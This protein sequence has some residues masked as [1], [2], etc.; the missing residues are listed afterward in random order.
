MHQHT[1][2][3]LGEVAANINS[4]SDT[5]LVIHTDISST[6][7]LLSPPGA[8]RNEFLSS[9]TLTTRGEGHLDQTTAQSPLV[10]QSSSSSMKSCKSDTPATSPV[11]Q[12]KEFEASGHSAAVSDSPATT[13]IWQLPTKEQL[14]ATIL[15][16]IATTLS[17]GAIA[18]MKNPTAANTKVETSFRRQQKKELAAAIAS[19]RRAA[20]FDVLNEEGEDNKSNWE[21][22]RVGLNRLRDL[23]SENEIA[24]L[25]LANVINECISDSTRRP[26]STAEASSTGPALDLLAEFTCRLFEDDGVNKE[27][28]ERP[29]PTLSPASTATSEREELDTC[30]AVP[31]YPSMPGFAYGWEPLTWTVPIWN[32]LQGAMADIIAELLTLEHDVDVITRAEAAA[33]DKASK[34]KT[35]SPTSPPNRFASLLSFGSSAINKTGIAFGGKPAA[36]A[37]AAPPPPPTGLIGAINSLFVEVTSA[38]TGPSLQGDGPCEA[39]QDP[40]VSLSQLSQVVEGEPFFIAKRSIVGQCVRDILGCDPL[41][42]AH[43]DASCDGLGPQ[44]FTLLPSSWHQVVWSLVSGSQHRPPTS[45]TGKSAMSLEEFLAGAF[46]PLRCIPKSTTSAEEESAATS[47]AAAS[48]HLPLAEWKA[49]Q[50]HVWNIFEAAASGM[51]RL[52]PDVAKPTG[53]DHWKRYMLQNGALNGSHGH[54]PAQRAHELVSSWHRAVTEVRGRESQGEAPLTIQPTGRGIF[55]S[56]HRLPSTVS[57]DDAASLLRPELRLNNNSSGTPSLEI[58]SRLTAQFLPDATQPRLVL[59]ELATLVHSFIGSVVSRFISHIQESHSSYTAYMQRSYH[60]P[61]VEEEQVAAKFVL[62]VACPVDRAALVRNEQWRTRH[63]IQQVDMPAEGASASTLA[64]DPSHPLKSSPVLTLPALAR[65]CPIP[66]S[67]VVNEYLPWLLNGTGTLPS[68]PSDEL[69]SGDDTLPAPASPASPRHWTTKAVKPNA[70]AHLPQIRAPAAAVVTPSI[71]STDPTAAEPG[72][73]LPGPVPC[74]TYLGGVYPALQLTLKETLKANNATESVSNNRPQTGGGGGIHTS[75]EI[76]TYTQ[77]AFPKV[78][79]A[80]VKSTLSP[81]QFREVLTSCGGETYHGSGF[82]F[83]DYTFFRHLL[84]KFGGGP[85]LVFNAPTADFD[86]TSII[87][88]ALRAG[89]PLQRSVAPL[90]RRMTPSASRQQLALPTATSRSTPNTSRAPLHTC[91]FVLTSTITVD[92]DD[93]IPAP[94]RRQLNSDIRNKVSRRLKALRSTKSKGP[95]VQGETNPTHAYDDEEEEEEEAEEEDDLRNSMLRGTCSTLAGFEDS[96]TI[97]VEPHTTFLSD[98]VILAGHSLL[99]HYA[100]ENIDSILE[101]TSKVGPCDETRAFLPLIQLAISNASGYRLQRVIAIG[102]YNGSRAPDAGDE[103]NVTYQCIPV[104]TE[105]TVKDACDASAKLVKSV[106]SAGAAE[107]SSDHVSFQVSNMESNVTTFLILLNIGYTDNVDRTTRLFP[108][109]IPYTHCVRPARSLVAYEIRRIDNIN[110]KKTDKKAEASST[111]AS[112]NGIPGAVGLTNIGNTCYMNSGLQCLMNLPRLRQAILTSLLSIGAYGSAGG[113]YRHNMGLTRAFRGLLRFVWSAGEAPFD[114]SVVD[115]EQSSYNASKSRSVVG[116]SKR[117]AN[118]RVVA[119]SEIMRAVKEEFSLRNFEFR[120]YEQH[121]ASLFV[122][123]F[124]ETLL[125]ETKMVTPLIPRMSCLQRGESIPYRDLRSNAGNRRLNS[126]YIEASAYWRDFLL[127]NPSPV[128]RHVYGLRH[129]AFHC[130]TCGA[131]GH[132]F[133]QNSQFLVPL[134]DAGEI[135]RKATAKRRLK[136]QPVTNFELSVVVRR[137]LNKCGSTSSLNER[138]AAVHREAESRGIAVVNAES[139]SKS[140]L[141]SITGPLPPAVSFDLRVLLPVRVELAIPVVVPLSAVF[142][143]GGDDCDDLDRGLDGQVTRKATPFR[144]LLATLRQLLRRLLSSPHASQTI[145]DSGVQLFDEE[146][147]K[148]EVASRALARASSRRAL[149]IRNSEVRLAFEFFFVDLGSSDKGSMGGFPQAFLHPGVAADGTPT[150]PRLSSHNYCVF[151][152]YRIDD[153]DNEVPETGRNIIR[154]LV[155]VWCSV[156]NSD[157][158]EVI[159]QAFYIVPVSESRHTEINVQAVM[160]SVGTRHAGSAISVSK[161]SVVRREGFVPKPLMVISDGN[162]VEGYPR[163]KD[164]TPDALVHLVLTQGKIDPT[165]PN[166]A[167]TQVLFDPSG[168]I[169]PIVD[170]AHATLPPLPHTRKTNIGTAVA[171]QYPIGGDE[172]AMHRERSMEECVF[173]NLS[174]S[175]IMSSPTSTLLKQS[176]TFPRAVSESTPLLVRAHTQTFGEE[177]DDEADNDDRTTKPMRTVELTPHIIFSVYHRT[178]LLKELAEVRK[179]SKKKPKPLVGSTYPISSSSPPVTWSSR[180]SGSTPRHSPTSSFTISHEATEYH[181]HDVD[182]SASPLPNASIKRSEEEQEGER[183]V[184]PCRWDDIDQWGVPTSD[185]ET[186]A[187]AVAPPKSKFSWGQSSYSSRVPV[188]PA[189]PPLNL[190][191]CLGETQ[192][193]LAADE[194]WMCPHCE[195]KREAFSNSQ[196]AILPTCLLIT[197]K[198]F[199]MCRRPSTSSRTTVSATFRLKWT[200]DPSWLR[201]MAS[202]HSRHDL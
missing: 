30:A 60:S 78:S 51:F 33:N 34:A 196:P 139:P 174:T 67:W 160:Q 188:A 35:T 15:S 183:L 151:P 101:G 129:N 42:R 84:L 126:R 137:A 138:I 156:L 43:S 50:D 119:S 154:T 178:L 109:A 158:T 23:L 104:S 26:T 53:V 25:G 161:C 24:Q 124:V 19:K 131:E 180:G 185:S 146:L 200:C 166:S 63:P 105:V 46:D 2:T 145:A 157:N 4:E 195:E 97:G 10:K 77:C 189:A 29:N 94:L 45:Y 123:A 55:D 114:V 40:E 14:H 6:S 113:N 163:C 121:D 12:G 130:L 37:A 79:S 81:A 39:G 176:S 71:T 75:V 173:H 167:W 170:A 7:A 54:G 134:E 116:I 102:D 111:Q 76:V 100:L 96:T 56:I 9:S 85:M 192:Q 108:T 117:S 190:L 106:P 58:L 194:R 22:Q 168:R 28:G 48:T 164:S 142:N 186:E 62:E 74:W 112:L 99:R 107:G 169:I 47:I 38:T 152:C 32:G 140:R 17:A 191:E 136:C 148:R 88:D 153:E 92:D 87:L 36:S 172:E 165:I 83:V 120:G 198:R 89:I 69:T 82:I 202:L 122:S 27:G 182:S 197:F 133:D 175:Q 179:E 171:G 5:S 52:P 91:R 13:R 90:A 70:R 118:D 135:K 64:M 80:G 128:A 61:T 147:A 141:I 127:S 199:S 31:G 177:V 65:L 115:S 8:P 18:G 162:P 11:A 73:F 68:S 201:R 159:E 193:L 3:A 16:H 110:E 181:P 41:A 21:Q 20:T 144:Y 49:V 103:A 187:E 150:V 184:D 59:S 132:N 57:R 125:A 149:D 72:T 98:A 86:S 155:T 1:Y 44:K 66:V 95:M 143:V 93:Q